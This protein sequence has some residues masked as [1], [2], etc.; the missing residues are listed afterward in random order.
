MQA[1][2]MQKALPRLDIYHISILNASKHCAN[3]YI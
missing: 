2:A 1:F 3:L